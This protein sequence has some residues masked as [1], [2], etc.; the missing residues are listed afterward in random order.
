[1]ENSEY[2][3]GVIPGEDGDLS[4]QEKVFEEKILNPYR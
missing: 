2:N 3:S 1:M 4:F